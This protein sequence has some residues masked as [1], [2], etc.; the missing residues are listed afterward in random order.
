MNELQKEIDEGAEYFENEN[1]N[2]EQSAAI[3]NDGFKAGA[4]FILDKN[5]DEQFAFWIGRE[6]RRGLKFGSD[7]LWYYSGPSGGG[8]TTKYSTK[9]LKEHW[10]EKIYGKEKP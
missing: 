7:G 8:D 2:D 9:N 4:K 3:A 1:N 6:T 5:L 10:L